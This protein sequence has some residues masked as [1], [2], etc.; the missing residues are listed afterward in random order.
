MAGH[1]KTRVRLSIT[2]NPALAERLR[3]EALSNGSTLSSLIEHTL[4]RRLPDPGQPAPAPQSDHALVNLALLAAIS[5]ARRPL[6]KP[7]AQ[8]KKK[9]VP[10]A[11]MR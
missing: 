5:L 1:P 9:A 11:Q 3:R 4:N 8:I 7:N 6:A 2:L 10:H